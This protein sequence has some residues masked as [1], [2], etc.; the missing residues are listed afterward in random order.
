MLKNLQ[1][2]ILILFTCI[3]TTCFSQGKEKVIQLSGIVV[4]GDSLDG[5]FGV[6]LYVP[7]AGRGATT[8]QVGFF[9]MP[10]LTGD[11]VVISAVGFLN[12]SY[13]IAKNETRDNISIMVELKPDSSFV[14]VI[15]VFPYYTEEL[16]KQAFLALKLPDPNADIN[17]TLLDR[18]TYNLYTRADMDGD[19]NHTYFMKQQIYQQEHR[20][21]APTIS[22][23]NPYA[24]MEF[25]KSLKRG[26]FKKKYDKD[27]NLIK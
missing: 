1:S 8:N 27:G 12:K 18:I 20:Y 7:K 24:W 21:M 4:S 13:F 5:V 25:V 10:V 2:Y 9:S 26:D 14:P 19:M 11:S 6:N 16:F 17:K 3:S 22:L 23:L 15:E